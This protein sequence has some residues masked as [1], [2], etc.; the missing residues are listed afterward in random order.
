MEK[1]IAKKL[2]QETLQGPFNKDRFIYLLKNIL[3]RFDESKAFHARGYVKEKFRDTTPIVKTYERLGTYTDSE[4][5]K[6]DL[7]IVY[8]QKENSIDRA[9]T[10]LRNFVADYL[11]DRDMKDAALVAFVA[12]GGND[13]RFSFVKMEYKFN[14]QG[15]VK[16]EYTPAKRYSFLVG[17]HENSHTAQRRLFEILCKNDEQN[18]TLKDLEEVFNVERVTK[19]FFE[20]YRELFLRCKESLDEIIKNSPGI[21][22]DFKNKNINTVDFVKKLLGQIVFLY[23]LQKNGWFGVKRPADW[24]ERSKY[25]LR[26]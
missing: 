15:K 18:P 6:I 20:K 3:N 13:W 25:F 26:E 7:L 4:E 8:L 22:A 12:P 23:F 10:S 21:K 5:K 16:E 9:R 24:E 17:E 1:D 14:E 11:K 19:E 2:V